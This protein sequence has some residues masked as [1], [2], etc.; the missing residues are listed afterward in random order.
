MTT[1]AVTHSD[2]S[3]LP[4]VPVPRDPRC[5]LRPPDVFAEWRSADGLQRV[6]WRGRPTWVISRYRDIRA[7]LVDPR[8][9]ADTIGEALRA[10]TADAEAP[11][12]FARIDDPEHN[13]LRRMMTRDFTVRRNEAMR[14]EIQALV[15]DL[16]DQMIARGGPAD[17]VRAFAL[18]VPSLVISLLLG[19]PY[20]DHEFF[21]L[22]STTGLDSRSTDEQKGAAIAALFGYISELVDR[23]TREP[24]DDL[25]SRLVVDFV[26]TGQLNRAT[27][28]MNAMILL[29]AGH[30]TTASM[31]ALGT[32][33]LLEHPDHWAT[34]QHTDSPQ[35]VAGIVEELLRYLTIVHS[36]V[37]RVA[38]EDLTIGGQLVRAGET[39]L[40]NLPAGNWDPDF[41]A[42]PEVF[43][44]TRNPRGH[45]A[46]GYGV[47]QCIGQHLARIELQVA[48]ATLARRLP[49]LR[50]AVPPE[51]L[52]F[53]NEQEIY[54]IGEL[55]VE[56]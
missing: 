3:V 23:K 42:E 55:P 31:I 22:H 56:W 1:G 27:A 37:D 34:L 8:L 43:D 6:S 53:Q 38:T 20:E 5:P 41:A 44:I 13:R 18:P 45:L 25:I 9:S 28:A 19:V 49:G 14:L 29:Q 2:D 50:P 36:L 40:M 4:G 16:L 21:Q 51:E 7:A 52:R 47:H 54:G 17:L 24:G 30:E 39:V 15:D 11:V 35:V 32:L 10:K 46:F 48:L 26:G 12:I 33:A